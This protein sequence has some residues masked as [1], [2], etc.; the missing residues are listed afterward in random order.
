MKLKY[1]AATALENVDI[2]ELYLSGKRFIILDIDNTITRWKSLD[3]ADPVKKWL[4]DAKNRGFELFLLS[5]NHN[6]QRSK[7]MAEKF[8]AKWCEIKHKKPSR[9]AFE[10]ALTYLNADKNLTVMIGDQMYGDMLGA[11]R[12]GIDGILLDPIAETEAPITKI[13]RVWERLMGRKI[14]YQSDEKTCVER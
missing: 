7:N 12:A 11:K 9:K 5:N 13:L 2:E 3:V 14:V 1:K 4:K 10:E 8:D 6:R